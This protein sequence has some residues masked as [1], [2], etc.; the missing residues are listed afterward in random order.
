MADDAERRRRREVVCAAYDEYG[1][2]TPEEKKSIGD[3]WDYGI[4]ALLRATRE[5]AERWSWLRT[6]HPGEVCM[7]LWE[8]GYRIP[9]NTVDAAIDAAIEVRGN[10]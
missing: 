6:N 3:C 5:D 8:R 9:L 7:M 4:D 1:R 10:D 2:M